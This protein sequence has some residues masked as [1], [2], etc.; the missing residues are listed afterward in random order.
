M[1]IEYGILIL[2]LCLCSCSITDNQLS[3]LALNLECNSSKQSH[4]SLKVIIYK[5]KPDILNFYGLS[6]ANDCIGSLAQRGYV[7]ID[8]KDTIEA[9]RIK[10]PNLFL[11][12]DL[13]S[14]FS[15]GIV[16]LNVENENYPNSMLSWVKMENKRSGHMFYLFNLGLY[17]SISVD[18]LQKVSN[19]VL[20]KIDFI[21]GAAPVILVCDFYKENS[22]IEGFL[23]DD[24]KGFYSIKM[25]NNNNQEKSCFFINDY[26]KLSNSFDYSD[27]E[28]LINSAEFEFVIN[29]KK[30]KRY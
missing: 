6:I 17:D 4:D 28:N 26:I 20:G 19:K 27:E 8:F 11:R 1:K 10:S 24:K 14:L 21:A 30:I 15:S 7:K 3:V 23:K 29:T 16:S 18:N 22:R 5:N 12:D 25:I 9:Y 13:F 2:I